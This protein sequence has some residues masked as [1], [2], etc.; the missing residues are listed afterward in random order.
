MIPTKAIRPL[1]ETAAAVPIVAATTTTSRT[2]ATL[3]PRLAASSSPTAEHV[4][5]APVEQDHDAS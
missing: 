3:T 5:H 1:T 4:E 2:R